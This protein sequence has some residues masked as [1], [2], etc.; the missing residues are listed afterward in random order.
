VSTNAESRQKD[1]KHHIRCYVKLIQA[2][3]FSGQ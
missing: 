1:T 3:S 2:K